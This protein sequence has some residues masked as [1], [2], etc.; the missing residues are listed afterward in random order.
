MAV[1]DATLPG[2]TMP[3]LRELADAGHEGK[4]QETAEEMRRSFPSI[5]A[6]GMSQKLI[7]EQSA[8]LAS[9]AAWECREFHG[10]AVPMRPAH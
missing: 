2:M 8:A 5:W 6:S 7:G 1:V 3:L 4:L 9:I 10:T